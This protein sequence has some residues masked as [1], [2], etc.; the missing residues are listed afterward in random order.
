MKQSKHLAPET[1]LSLFHTYRVKAIVE[2]TLMLL[3]QRKKE[4][5]MKREARLQPTSFRKMSIIFFCF[6]LF[7]PHYQILLHSSLK[8]LLKF[9]LYL[10]GQRPKVFNHG[11][12]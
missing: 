5:Q 4:G 7:L 10:V 11:S 3:T 6:Q 1:I 12:H 2:V 9:C 8:L